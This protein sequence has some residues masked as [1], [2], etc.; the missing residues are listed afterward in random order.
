ME[1]IV[2]RV[3]ALDVHKAQRHGVRAGARRRGVAVS[4]IW[5][6]STTTVR[7]LLALSDWLAE[8]SVDARRD[9]IDRRL[10]EA[11]LQPPRRRFE[12]HAG[13]RAARQAGPRPQ[14]RYQGRRS[15]SATAAGRPAAGQLCAARSRSGK[16]RDLTR[17]RKTQIHDRQREANRLQK[18]LE[19]A[20][21]K[22]GRVASDMLGVSGRRCWR[23][24]WPG[25][26][27]GL[28][29]RAGE[30]PAAQEDPRAA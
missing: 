20:N 13:Q 6:S 18:A 25:D 19:D 17:H 21:I 11:G 9:G 4:R 14:D 2:E 8:P 29:G 24:W 27:P 23:R 28:A 7:G 10:L 26:R 30:G 1:V 12:C 5:P 15:G 3:A 16:L 22:L